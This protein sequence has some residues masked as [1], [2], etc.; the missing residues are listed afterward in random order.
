MSD[1]LTVYGFEESTYVRTVRMVLAEKG[2]EYDLVPVNIMEGEGTQPEHLARQLAHR[3]E[4]LGR[5]TAILGQWL[6]RRLAAMAGID[7]TRRDIDQAA[8]PRQRTSGRGRG[9]DAVPA[10]DGFR[11][12]KRNKSIWWMPWRT[13]AMKDAARCEKPWGAASRR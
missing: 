3:V 10:R 7:R 4:P 5:H 11:W 9:R 2:A 6:A 12:I 8:Q 1:K 13:E